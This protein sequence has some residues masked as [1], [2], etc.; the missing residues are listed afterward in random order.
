MNEVDDKNLATSL[1]RAEL[2]RLCLDT[3]R[4]YSCDT[5]YFKDKD[6]R[7]LW[8]SKQHAA[9]VGVTCPDDMI[10]KTD[11]DFFPQ[12]FAQAA[13]DVEIEIMRTEL[14]KLNIPE[15]LSR[16]NGDKTYYLA[17]KYPFYNEKNEIIGTWGISRNITDQKRLE[18]ELEKSNQKLQRL[19]RVDDLTGLYN[20]RYFYETLERTVSIYDARPDDKETFALIAIDIDDMKYINDQY[21]HT[22]GDDVLCMVSSS[23]LCSTKKTDTCYRVGGDEFMVMV[24]DCELKDAI[25]L[26]KKIA[27]AVADTAVPMCD[28]FERITVSLGLAMYK[29]GTDISDLI[30]SADRK[31]YK[32]KR[33]G[34]NQVSF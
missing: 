13:R 33:N 30:S 24:P 29:K 31:L 18:K 22:H 23:M 3:V 11:F 14:P 10:G 28:K 34:K 12:E 16:D 6:S 2:D 9:Q 8:N 17:S 5:V 4:E 32:S 26:A 7:F 15:E 19:A 20:R 25:G 1:D 27:T 21:G